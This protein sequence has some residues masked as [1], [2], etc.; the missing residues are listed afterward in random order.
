MFHTAVVESD[1]FL[2]LPLSAQALYFH[3][4]MHA[5]DDGFVNNPRQICRMIGTSGKNLEALVEKGFLLRFGDVVVVKHWLVA[6]TLK[7]DRMKVPAFPDIAEKICIDR[8]RQYCDRSDCAEVSLLESRMQILDSKKFQMDSKRNPKVREGKVSEDKVSEDKVREDKV[9]EDKITEDKAAV[10]AIPAGP[11]AA[12]AADTV[13]EFLKGE[14]GK[15]VVL[16]SEA[17]IAELL[18]QLGLDGFDHYV[19]KLS[20]FILKSGAKVKNHYATILKWWQEDKECR[21]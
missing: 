14:L 19:D 4:S 17:Q 16:L 18:D 11:E 15:G 1:G 8:N 9:R 12:A 5:D 21:L 2:D 3:I 13:P 10:A 6:N 7:K 20:D